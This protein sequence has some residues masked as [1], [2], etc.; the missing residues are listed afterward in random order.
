MNETAY[1]KLSA[2][3][4]EPESLEKAIV[5]LTANL[6]QFLKERDK[7]LILLPDI[8]ATVGSLM[9]EAVLR[10]GA[11]PQFLE[12]DNRWITILKTAFVSR[13]DCI[14]GQP[15]TLLGLAKVAKHMGTPL[16]ARN[17]LI[18]GYPSKEWMIKGIEHGLDCRVWGCYDPGLSAMI[19]G[20]NCRDGH[21]HLRHDRYHAWIRDEKGNDLP[22]GQTGRVMLSPTCDL[23]IQFDTGDTGRIEY[24][25]CSCGDSSPRLADLTTSNGIHR[26]LSDLWESLHYWGSILDCKISSCGYGLE[27]EVIVFPGEKL[28]KFP[29]CAKLV[30][31]AWNPEK[32]EPFPHA[33]ILKRRLFSRETH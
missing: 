33:Y 5:Y 23:T 27:L 8:P 18:G 29:S 24:A 30:V 17:V 26:D 20:F 7:V 11:V 25:P 19:A 21:I 16:F 10:C 4:S 32:D 9:K 1:R 22:K 2:L 28:P 31:R 6:R 12:D 14:I 15:L 13:C 3:A